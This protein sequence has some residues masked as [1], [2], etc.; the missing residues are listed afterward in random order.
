MV[1]AELSIGHFPPHWLALLQLGI[2][3]WGE[4]ELGTTRTYL[5]NNKD[6]IHFSSAM[7]TNAKNITVPQ[8]CTMKESGEMTSQVVGTGSVTPSFFPS[9]TKQYVNRRN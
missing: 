7:Q 5:L 8:K 2:L 6:F 4:N 9:S 1:G 3:A